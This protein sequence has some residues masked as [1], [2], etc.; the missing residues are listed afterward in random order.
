MSIFNRSTL[1]NWPKP[2]NLAVLQ[3]LLHLFL[4]GAKPSLLLYI[5]ALLLMTSKFDVHVL[6]D[7]AAIS[8][9]P[10]LQLTQHHCLHCAATLAPSQTRGD[11]QFEL[12]APKLHCPELC[13]VNTYSMKHGLLKTSLCT[14]KMH[15]LVCSVS[16]TINIPWLNSHGSSQ[17]CAQDTNAVI[18]SYDHHYS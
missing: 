16:Y 5:D 3:S 18:L 15:K 6:C 11:I 17:H 1:K 14:C 13:P 8:M 9:L 10:C 2:D 7:T 4:H 12:F